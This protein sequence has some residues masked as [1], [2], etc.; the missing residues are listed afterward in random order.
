MWSEFQAVHRVE[1]GDKPVQLA[2]RVECGFASGFFRV[3]VGEIE[4]LA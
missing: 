4:L 3:G 1:L 2:H